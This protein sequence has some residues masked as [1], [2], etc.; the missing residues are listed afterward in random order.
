MKTHRLSTL[1]VIISLPT[2][3]IVT[4]SASLANCGVP[5]PVLQGALAPESRFTGCGETA[6]AFFWRH[7]HAVQRLVSGSLLEGPAGAD[8]GSSSTVADYV[9]TP[10]AVPG[11]Y[12][13]NTD[14]SNAGTDGCILNSPESD[15]GCGTGQPS[16]PVHDFVLAGRM[17]SDP[18]TALAAVVS[19]DFNEMFQ[20]WIL[21]NAGAPSVDGNACGGDAFSY[22]TPPEIPCA[23]IPR[24]VF[25]TVSCDAQACTVNLSVAPSQV[26]ILDDCDVAESRA[27]NCT[28]PAGDRRDLFVGRQLFFKKA[29]CLTPPADTRTYIMTPTPSPGTITPNFIAYSVEDAN[30]NGSLDPGEDGSNGGTVN[31]RLDPYILTGN[32]AETRT[33]SIPVSLIP[34]ACVY[35]GVG[36]ALDRLPV[37]PGEPVVTPLVSMNTTPL[38]ASCS[39]RDLDEDGFSECQGDCDDSNPSIHP[40]ALEICNGLDDDCDG[41]VDEGGDALCPDSNSCTLDLCGGSSG[42]SHPPAADGTS[43][44]DRMSCTTNDACQAG[45]CSGTAAPAISV[46]LTPA[47][48]MPANHQMETI[49]ASVTARDACDQPLSWVLTSVTS[50]EPDDAPGSSDGNTVNDI[51]NASPGT[52][53]DSFDLRAERDK[54]GPGRVYTVVYTAT[55]TSGQTASTTATVVVPK[56]PNL[57]SQPG[58]PTP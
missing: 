46:T 57:G 45:V 32:A 2:L 10:G 30:L 43:C 5:A 11:D 54:L 16:P 6:Y 51:Q 15:I 53:D 33:V 24:P 44:D 1:L 52:P 21:D 39:T 9:M 36:L 8:S 28:G 40:G 34:D 55:G 41:T 38:R 4:A 35:L 22:K 12:F 47:I 26:P 23:A 20:L 42:C 18:A 13:G 29:S 50:S 49:T 48:L 37:A 25:N 3:L 14:W 7:Q 56:N 17:T 27:L 31:G 19:V 58:E